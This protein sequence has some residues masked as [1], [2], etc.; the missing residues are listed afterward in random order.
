MPFNKGFEFIADKYKDV[1]TSQIPQ[2]WP[3]NFK[4]DGTMF[5]Y[6][7]YAYPTNEGLVVYVK[8]Q[9]KEIQLEQEK[10]FA[11]QKLVES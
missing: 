9:T 2:N 8:D 5:Y 1:V 7:I 10:Q 4:F 11:L 3:N 6:M